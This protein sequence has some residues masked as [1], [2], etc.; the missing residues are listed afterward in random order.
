M[1]EVENIEQEIGE[2]AE[3]LSVEEIANT[4]THGFGL[5]LAVVGLVVLLI[6][7]VANGDRMYIAA[8]AIYGMSMVI[9]YAA[10]TCYHGA[11]SPGLKRALHFAD[12]AGI[13]LLTAGTYTPFVL[14]TF[15]GSTFGWTLFATVWTLAITFI[16]LRAL[17]GNKYR[18]LWVASFLLL[19][20]M[21]VVAI[22]PLFSL[23]GWGAVAL[24]LGGGLAY[25]IGVIFYAAQRIPHNHAIWHVFVMMGSILH[26]AAI[27]IYV[28]PAGA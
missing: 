12:Y 23:I 14:V 22:G 7:A 11:R 26:Y 6:M 9:L 3:A 8:S 28:R 17:I 5:A 24:I 4:I 1:N 27:V 18:P 13:Y 15:Q 21:G 25:S 2:I 19:G 16:I 20:W 10:S